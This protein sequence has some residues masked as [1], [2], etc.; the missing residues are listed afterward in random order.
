ME[1]LLNFPWVRPRP[2]R[3]PSQDVVTFDT[4]LE[5]A[6]SLEDGRPA[7]P[8][9][10][11]LMTPNDISMVGKV[12]WR[13]TRVVIAEAPD[14]KTLGKRWCVGWDNRWTSHDAKF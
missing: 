11:C 5:R 12:A 9:S 13:N 10:L 14:G 6:S 1:T 7:S 8:S 2:A 4:Q 3:S